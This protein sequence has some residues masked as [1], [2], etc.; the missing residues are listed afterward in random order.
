MGKRICRSQVGLADLHKVEGA[1]AE[2]PRSQV[3]GFA[4][5]DCQDAVQLD[6]RQKASW[7]LPECHRIA[8]R[9]PTV[10]GIVEAALYLKRRKQNWQI[11]MP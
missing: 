9:L 8:S 1:S 3:G 4:R 11:Q 2:L 5:G 7:I 6:E 10:S